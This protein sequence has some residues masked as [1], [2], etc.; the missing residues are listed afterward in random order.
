MYKIIFYVLLISVKSVFAGAYDF[1]E[2]ERP[3]KSGHTIPFD[4]N[5]KFIEACA[6]DTLYAWLSLDHVLFLAQEA[7]ENRSF[8]K[9]EAPLFTWR[10]PIGTFGYAAPH[11][12][13]I[14]IKL[15]SGVKF[16]YSA[17]GVD[18]DD[19]HQM[20][21]VNVSYVSDGSYSEYVICSSDVIASWS[22]GM[23]EHFQEMIREKNWIQSHL[24]GEYD[25]FVRVKDLSWLNELLDSGYKIEQSNL[26]FNF[27]IDVQRNES[28]DWTK[29]GLDKK[30]SNTQ[31]LLDKN[32]G[33]IFYG[34]GIEHNRVDHFQTK[35]AQTFMDVT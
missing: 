10:T 2:C 29:A 14:R 9:L 19:S 12:V 21:S 23:S 25:Q 4:E 1:K 8:F 11:G 15:R 17:N 20:N 30:L 33:E 18:C 6:P 16:N 5:R 13:S 27:A 26:F 3:E 28:I 35:K 22:F 32:E 7:R 34:P 24:V 31:Q